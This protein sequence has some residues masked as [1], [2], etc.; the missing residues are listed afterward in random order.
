MPVSMASVVV[1]RGMFDFP[2]LKRSQN[3]TQ[4]GNHCS[5]GLVSGWSVKSDVG[6]QSRNLLPK[7]VFSYTA[8]GI[9]ATHL[10]SNAFDPQ[11][12]LRSALDGLIRIVCKGRCRALHGV[13]ERARNH[14]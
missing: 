1:S 14:L 6:V 12:D 8:D 7:I 9:H 5:K 3:A 13:L 2:C 4:H 11:P 10:A